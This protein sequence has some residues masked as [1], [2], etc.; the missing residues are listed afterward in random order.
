MKVD[1]RNN[2]NWGRGDLLYGLSKARGKYIRDI[3]FPGERQKDDGKYID[4]FN[5]QFFCQV[6]KDGFKDDDTIEQ[7]IKELNSKTGSYKRLL[8]AYKKY[9]PQ[10]TLSMNP[11]V[12]MQK[13]GVLGM[14]TRI[15][16]ESGKLKPNNPKRKSMK[17][18][19]KKLMQKAYERKA[20]RRGCKYGLHMVARELNTDH[21]NA[22]IHFLLDGLNLQDAAKKTEV[23][24]TIL[25]QRPNMM[26]KY[27]HI[28]TTE[29]R[30]A[31]KYWKQFKKNKI[32]FYINGEEVGPPWENEWK[33]KK[34]CLYDKEPVLR[35]ND[36]RWWESKTGEK[37]K[38]KP[39]I[40]KDVQNIRK[41]WED[42]IK[43]NQI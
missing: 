33:R 26:I 3:N 2:V 23:D 11:F 14:A 12:V 25:P 21:P 17:N 30:S 41:Q 32:H 36:P 9:S 38:P 35:D 40:K 31:C 19:I 10:M 6:I 13:E 42:R 7:I 29:L 1:F 28:T 39:I 34:D 27:I 18:E 22:Q 20:I 5:N 16:K 37:Y 15:A 8:T 4:D 43:K 24:K